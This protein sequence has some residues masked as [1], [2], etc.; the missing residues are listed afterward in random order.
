MTIKK[1]HSKGTRQAISVAILF[2]MSIV[3]AQPA[4]AQSQWTT[5]GNNINNTNTGNVGVGTTSPMS[6][7]HVASAPTS[8]FRG[9]VVS[10]HTDDGNAAFYTLLKARGT[11]ASPTAVINGDNLG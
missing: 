11:I 10:Q 8:T 2:A 7:L 3:I 9:I 6:T 1:N 5:N 4:S